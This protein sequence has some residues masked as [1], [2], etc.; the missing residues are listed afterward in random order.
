MQAGP[1]AVVYPYIFL[2][3][4]IAVS[5][6]IP[7]FNRNRV[8]AA[9]GVS[10]RLNYSL[11]VKLDRLPAIHLLP[12]KL[13]EKDCGDGKI[14]K[15]VVRRGPPRA[16][17]RLSYIERVFGSI[18]CLEVLSFSNN[19]NFLFSVNAVLVGL[20]VEGRVSLLRIELRDY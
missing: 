14:I 1:L 15:A 6:D 3:C 19:G 9:K 7:P 12:A 16:V 17:V 13:R 10:A 4:F 5:V 11:C 8:R 18:L 2:S 20:I